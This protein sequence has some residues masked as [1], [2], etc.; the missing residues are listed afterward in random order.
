[1]RKIYLKSLFTALLL[2]C[3]SVLC[4]QDISVTVEGFYYN[5]IYYKF[6]GG[7]TVSVG[8]GNYSGHI[9]IPE[10]VVCNIEFLEGYY[11]VTGI[12]DRA[13]ENCTELT[14]VT[15]GNSV[16]A[17]GK[18]AFD[19]CTALKSITI[20]ASVTSIYI[21][22]FMGC[23]GITEVIFEDGTAPLF[24]DVKW[25]GNAYHG[26]AGA[27][28]DSPLETVYLG[29]QITYPDDSWTQTSPFYSTSL[30]NVTITENVTN[31]S[32][33]LFK[34]CDNLQSVTI[35]NSVT[36]IGNYAFSGCS[37]L[38]SVT[39]PNS[40]TTIGKYAFP[41]CYGLT[42]ITIPNSVKTIGEQAF[43]FCS[44]L[45]SV[46][47]GNSVESV[48]ENAFQMNPG[49]ISLSEVHISNLSAWCRINF[50]GNESNPLYYAKKLY[51][52][53]QLFT[54]LVIPKEITEIKPFA[55][56]SCESIE[57]V[58][59]HNNITKIS[60][61]AFNCCKN[62]TGN[63]VI[64]DKVTEIGH[65]AFGSCSKLTGDPVIPDKVNFIGNYAFSG[66]SGLTSV[67]IPNSVTS[68]GNGAFYGCSSLT[69][70]S[71][72]NSVTTIGYDAFSGCS[73]LKS[74][75]IPNSV[76]TIGGGAFSGCI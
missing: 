17:I 56:R 15:I 63:L 52:N 72:G 76:K 51:L 13:F 55:F 45:A 60:Q 6:A 75:T 66:C 44:N 26:T 5:S 50:S 36:T 2:L 69:S 19:G 67:T 20:P 18:Y 74:V 25:W 71:I 58:T 12:A 41:Y 23:T 47:M 62:L 73:N 38:A 9:D 65:F 37:N 34:D 39:I 53:G 68:I 33:G 46:T 7:N 4:A 49:S 10:T 59:F 57:S 1:M 24:I 27:F 32:D 14:S 54:D 22:A 16:E 43:A 42:N 8:P 61:D 11:T 40:V 28:Y 29:R 48:G 3:S 64:P 31:I 30:K 35:P 70:V 21:G